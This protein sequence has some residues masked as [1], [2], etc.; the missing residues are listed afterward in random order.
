METGDIQAIDPSD[1]ID[2]SLPAP[3]R[4]RLTFS[5]GAGAKSPPSL[6]NCGSMVV[7]PRRCP[8]R[9]DRVSGGSTNICRLDLRQPGLP[10]T[11][12]TP[13]KDN[14][15]NPAKLLIGDASDPAWDTRW[16]MA[17]RGRRALQPP[18]WV[19]GVTGKL[20]QQGKG[21]MASR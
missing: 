13:E 12:L 19:G 2:P 16:R 4:G 20:L 5:G 8:R 18:Y 14:P 15:A 6:G 17:S 3:T 21:C 1:A 9:L 7:L 11:F 10:V